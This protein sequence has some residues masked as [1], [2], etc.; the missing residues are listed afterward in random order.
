MR[1]M[2]LGALGLTIGAVLGVG[3]LREVLKAC[4]AAILTEIRASHPEEDTASAE[5][6]IAQFHAT[7]FAARKAMLSDLKARNRMGTPTSLDKA[8]R[9][10]LARAHKRDIVNRSLMI[11]I[12][13]AWIITVPA[14]AILSALVFFTLRGKLMP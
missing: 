4:H 13:A 3:F 12:F 14:P 8:D 2:M 11:R 7:P 6:F 9:K 1:V 5:A 10:A